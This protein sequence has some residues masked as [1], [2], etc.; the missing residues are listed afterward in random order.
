MTTVIIDE[1]K[2]TNSRER[3]PYREGTRFTEYKRTR[4]FFLIP[5]SRMTSKNFTNISQHCFRI[6]LRKPEN[7]V[8]KNGRLLWKNQFHLKKCRQFTIDKQYLI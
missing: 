1:E 3:K 5:G 7:N 2:E 4:R 8:N 6:L